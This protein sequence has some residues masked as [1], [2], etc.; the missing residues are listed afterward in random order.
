[1]SDN[2]NQKERA[3]KSA[4]IL[5]ITSGKGGVGK[6][7]LSVNLA[8]ELSRRGHRT[9]VVDTDLGLANAHILAGIRP[10]KTLSD[11]IEGKAELAEIIEDGP[12]KVKF[13]SGGSGVKEMANLDDNGRA[14]ICVAIEELQPFCDVILLDTGAGVSKGV[15]DFV[16]MA[17]QTILVT[18]SNFASI[19][20]AYGIVKVVVQDGYDRPIHCVVNRVRS[21]EEAEQV[22]LKL[23][24]CT[25]RFLGFDLNWL[26]LLPEDSSVEGAVLKRSPFS[27]IFPGSVAARYL[28][29]LVTGL[30][31]YIG[32]PRSAPQAAKS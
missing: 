8:C 29:K 3:S 19:A 31:R 14:R 11:Y 7:S 26:G 1:M 15:T 13:I 32:A 28:A 10:T 21:P 20:D 2:L 27:E 24:G 23:K 30:E 25:E 9:I 5:A 17:E 18:T 4:K 16:T 22:F 12:C 6:T